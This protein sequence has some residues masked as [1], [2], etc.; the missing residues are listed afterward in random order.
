M[1]DDPTIFNRGG[2]GRAINSSNIGYTTVNRGG[3][4]LF[5]Y[6][7]AASASFF[8]PLPPIY[9]NHPSVSTNFGNLL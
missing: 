7:R 4:G 6:T 2:K 9:F 3:G 1:L 8:P 5:N